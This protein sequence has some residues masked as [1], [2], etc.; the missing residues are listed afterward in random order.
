MAKMFTYTECNCCAAVSGGQGFA[1]ARITSHGCA[2]PRGFFIES[3]WVSAT[4]TPVAFF[5]LRLRRQ[6]WI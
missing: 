1:F 3:R 2:P 6:T 4:G 5:I